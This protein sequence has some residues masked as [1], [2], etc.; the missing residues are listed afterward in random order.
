MF[1]ICNVIQCNVGKHI[2]QKYF[3]SAIFIA[4][5]IKYN[6]NACKLFQMEFKSNSA[7]NKKTKP[8]Q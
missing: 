1:Y 5:S 3:M 7:T 4:V 6:L 2:T 8:K